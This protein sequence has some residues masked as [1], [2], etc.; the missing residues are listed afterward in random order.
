MDT[1]TEE[2]YTGL[3]L[4][5]FSFRT[6]TVKVRYLGFIT[7]TRARTLSHYSRKKETLQACALSLLREVMEDGKVRRLGIRLSLFEKPDARQ[8][9]LVCSYS[10][11][12]LAAMMR[13]PSCYRLITA[14]R[15]SGYCYSAIVRSLR[16]LL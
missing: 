16:G 9:T 13:D 4:E 2:I 11:L 5:N 8:I 1:L 10:D 7:W 6:L 14:R 3:V 12:Y 15:I